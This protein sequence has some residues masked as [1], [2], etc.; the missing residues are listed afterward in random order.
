[1]K[2]FV[3]VLVLSML[4]CVVGCGVFKN[5]CDRFQDR[6][7]VASNCE[8]LQLLEAALVSGGKCNGP[9]YCE[10]SP[11]NEIEQI[12]G[13]RAYLLYSPAGVV[14]IEGCDSAKGDIQMWKAILQ[15]EDSAR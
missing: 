13:H 14:F 1:M 8:K 5:S 6:W 4:C 10:V 9:I 7:A 12:T 15:C 2:Q 3:Y 11:I